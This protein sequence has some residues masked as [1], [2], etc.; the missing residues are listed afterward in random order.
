MRQQP[1]LLDH[2]DRGRANVLERG[3]VTTFLEPGS[4]DR[5]PLLRPVPQREQR[6]LAAEAPPCL[7]DRH[8]L[9]GRQERTLEL[10][11]WLGERAVMAVVA[12]QHRERDEDL[13]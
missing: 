8:D 11:R 10:G 6:F 2:A 9:L 1:G 4:R 13:A 3:A 5:V 7:G 12:T